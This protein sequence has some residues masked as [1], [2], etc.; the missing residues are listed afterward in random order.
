VEM[1]CAPHALAGKCIRLRKSTATG[2]WRVSPVGARTATGALLVG[3]FSTRSLL[4]TTRVVQSLRD[5]DCGQRLR[6][7]SLRQLQARLANVQFGPQIQKI[8]HAAGCH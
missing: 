3:D 8:T 1:S 4:E 5:R 6:G 7:A 2:F